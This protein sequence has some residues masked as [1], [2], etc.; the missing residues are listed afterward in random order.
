MSP[1]RVARRTAPARPHS[2]IQPQRIKQQQA[3]DL[4]LTGQ[5][6]TLRAPHVIVPIQTGGILKA[7]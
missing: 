4:N 7:M 6:T 5:T 3:T 2:L 1:P